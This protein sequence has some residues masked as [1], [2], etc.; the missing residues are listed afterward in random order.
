MGRRGGLGVLRTL[1]TMGRNRI[2]KSYR[3]REEIREK[4]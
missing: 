2:R 3:R 4:V 1:R